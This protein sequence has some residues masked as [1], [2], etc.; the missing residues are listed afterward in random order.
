M[1]I[2]TIK[3][4]LQ[5]GIL[6]VPLFIIFL[7]I[8]FLQNIIGDLR[9]KNVKEKMRMRRRQREKEKEVEEALQLSGFTVR[10]SILNSNQVSV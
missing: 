6:H 2:M 7:Y 8:F 3:E 9:E 4:I 10:V 5:R 1:V